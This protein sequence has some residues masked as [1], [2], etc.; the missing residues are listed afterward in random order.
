MAQSTSTL[1]LLICSQLELSFC[2]STKLHTHIRFIVDVVVIV[3][4][5]AGLLLLPFIYTLDIKEL[6]FLDESG[7]EKRY[8]LFFVQLYLSFFGNSSLFSTLSSL[9]FCC[10]HFAIRNVCGKRHMILLLYLSP[11]HFNTHKIRFVYTFFYFIV[12]QHTMH[13][14]NVKH[15]S[16]SPKSQ[17]LH[18]RK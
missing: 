8:V 18:G 13:E 10:I 4:T 2:T 3:S 16:P 1:F 9:S 5:L 7:C 17:Y 6:E 11:A 15:K 12:P 14:G